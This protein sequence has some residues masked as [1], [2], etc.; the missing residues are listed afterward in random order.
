[1]ETSL[2]KSGVKEEVEDLTPELEGSPDMNYN[3]KN[4]SEDYDLL[5]FGDK[6]DFGMDPELLRTSQNIGGA[7]GNNRPGQGANENAA[8]RRGDNADYG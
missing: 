3:R 5:D 2:V 4:Y 1:L 6:M 7:F 8:F